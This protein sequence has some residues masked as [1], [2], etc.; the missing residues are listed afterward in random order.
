[1]SAPVMYQARK[2]GALQPKSVVMDSVSVPA[3]YAATP[4][5]HQSRCRRSGCCRYR[6]QIVMA[7]G[8]VRRVVTIGT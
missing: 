1:M 6:R 3:P 4:M 7:N 8:T 5:A 2:P